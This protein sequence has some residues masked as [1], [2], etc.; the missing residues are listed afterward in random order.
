MVRATRW[1]V[2]LLVIA[3]L[4]IDAYV[5]AD[6]AATFDPIKASIS[7]GTLFRIEA[8]AASAAALLLVVSGRRIAWAVAA[9]VLAAGFAAVIVYQFVDIPAFGPFPRM[10]DPYWTFEKGLSVVA[11]GAGALLAVAVVLLWPGGR[12]AAGG[13]AGGRA[14]GA[15]TPG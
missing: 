12:A 9:A 8:G 15:D 7:Q 11:E 6:L 5:H 3:C 2:R 14:G 4:V 13:R 10:Y 1:V